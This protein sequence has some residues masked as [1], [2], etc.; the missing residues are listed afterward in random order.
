MVF[1]NVTYEK[2]DVIFLT[3]ISFPLFIPDSSQESHSSGCF[4]A[5]STVQTSNGERRK[6]SELRLGE[7]VLS[8]DSAGNAVY[9]E[10]IMFM[11]R[12][13][14]QSREFVRLD[15]DGGAS[16][17]AT[18]GHLLLVWKY[19]EQ[20]QRFM[21][22]EK[23]EEGDFLLVNV[24]GTIAPRKV[25]RVSAEL[26]RGVYAPL[27]REGTIVVNGVTASCY[28]MVDSQRIAH[29]SFLPVRWASAVG[30]W[31]KSADAVP[32]MSRQT[33]IHWYANALY[34]IKDYFLPSDWIYKT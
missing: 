25:L 10:V 19:E 16:L 6:L 15:T 28:A 20:T 22:A 9:S 30:S 27:T 2:A 26:H 11:D 23:V 21:Y 29:W 12:D 5:N 8:M 18:P 3:T 24:N 34:S 14:N 1:D 33:G 17:T 31:F 4:T 13:A 7:K 32:E